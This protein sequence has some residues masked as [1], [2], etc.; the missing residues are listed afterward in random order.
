MKKLALLMFVLLVLAGCATTETYGVLPFGPDTYRLRGEDTKKYKADNLVIDEATKY[1]ESI[2]KHFM[3]V[4]GSGSG[5][6]YSLIFKC[7]DK[8]DPALKSSSN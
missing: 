8:G 2:N 4:Q 7:L 5:G 3:P 6:S 1:C